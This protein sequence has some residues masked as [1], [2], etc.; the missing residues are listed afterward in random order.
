MKKNEEMKAECIQ[1]LQNLIK[2]IQV[3]KYSDNYVITEDVLEWQS[4]GL[5]TQSVVR[6]AITRNEYLSK[7]NKI[8]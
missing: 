6:Y 3:D 4:D 1:Y 2:D 7:K 5:N 8:F